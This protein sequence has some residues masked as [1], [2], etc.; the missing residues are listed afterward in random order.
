MEVQD[1]FV[2]GDRYASSTLQAS[3]M[4]LGK[5]KEGTYDHI[6]LIKGIYNTIDFP[7]LFKQD[8]GKKLLDILGTGWPSL[9]LISN[10][11]KAILEENDLTGWKIFPIILYDKKGIEISGY[12]GFSVTGR[13]GPIDDQK[14][15][16]VDR[17]MIS[18]GP[19]F[20][21]YKG[22]YVGLDEWDG[23]DFFIPENSL[24]CIVTKKTANILKKDKK[25]NVTLENCAEFETPLN[26]V[27]NKI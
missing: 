14:A 6:N 25:L 1:F 9:Y 21:A 11:T 17:Q 2:F 3:P 13:C 4:E 26:A 8:C 5:N 7:V 23:T 22:L 24:F 18:T 15:K 19:V 20:K 16:I 27:L 10:K 12:H